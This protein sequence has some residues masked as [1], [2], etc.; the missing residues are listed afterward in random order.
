MLGG[1]TRGGTI[2]TGAR[3]MGPTELDSRRG[4]ADRALVGRTREFGELCAVLEEAIAGRGGLALLAGEPGIGKTRLAEELSSEAG[5]RSALVLWG[6][7]WDDGGAPAYWPWVQIL[8]ALVR[9]RPSACLVREL[10]HAAPFVAH[11]VPE[12]RDKL[13]DVAPAP[14][15]GS[16]EE[17]RF[18]L[19]DAVTAFLVSVASA[20]PMVLVVDD[21][22]AADP[23]SLVLLRFLARELATV[24]I[25]VLGT[26]RDVGATPA[27]AVSALIGELVRDARQI[28]LKGLDRDAVARFVTQATGS[29]PSDGAAASIH[30]ATGGNP[31]FLGQVLELLLD[32]G[33]LP[34]D[35]P[36]ANT[37]PLPP[38][39][40]EAIRARVAMLPDRAADTL[41]LAAVTGTEP[42]PALVSEAA[43]ADLRS[44]IEDFATA[45]DA[46]LLRELPDAPG[47]FRFAHA[48]IRDALYGTLD[49]PARAELHRDVGRAIERVRLDEREEHLTALAHHFCCAAAIGEGEKGVGY[50]VRAAERAIALLA[51]EEAAADYEL[52]LSTLDL[53]HAG[54]IPQRCDILLGLG[55]AERHASRAE[56]SRAA[57]EAAAELATELDDP[58]R[59]AGAALGLGMVEAGASG[60]DDS[61]VVLLERALAALPDTDSAL[62]ARVLARLARE[63]YFGD[64]PERG[65]ELCRRAVE[66]ARRGGDS[67][68]LLEVLCAEHLVTWGPD[69][70]QERLR[71]AGEIVA[72]AEAIEDRDVAMQGRMWRM[73]HLLERGD[74]RAL[75]SELAAFE[76]LA[77]ELRQPGYRRQAAQV[78]AGRALLR[79]RFE[80][81]ERLA[82]EALTIGRPGAGSVAEVK[83]LYQL[84]I[85][86]AEL[87]RLEEVAPQFERFG[88]LYAPW[89]VDPLYHLIRLGRRGEVRALFEQLATDGFEDL[90]QDKFWLWNLAYLAEAAVFLR[91][92]PRAA[93]LYELLSPYRDVCLVI[94]QAAGC[95]GPLAH[96]LGQ[97]AA[98]LERWNDAARHFDRALEI[99]ERMGARPLL[100]HTEHEYARALLDRGLPGDHERATAMLAEALSTARELGMTALAERIGSAPAGPVPATRILTREGEYWTIAWGASTF[101]L[102]HERGLGFIAHLL[103]H[104]NEEIH[105]L[106]LAGT[107]DAPAPDASLATRFN[108][109]TTPATRA[110]GLGDAGALLDP[111]AKAA[112]RQRLADLREEVEAAQRWG[113]PERAA[114]AEAEIDFLTQELARALGLGGKDRKAAAPAERARVSVTK[115]IKRATGKIAAHDERLGRHLA[116]TLRTGTFCVYAPGLADAAD[117]Q[118]DRRM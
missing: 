114:N 34:G 48:L 106:E 92:R 86:C 71:S 117:P 19:L 55:A 109:A 115:A 91:D 89:R 3:E 12:V 32:E 39:A 88:E 53:A 93:R 112:Y 22:H 87:G 69:N 52:A 104:P 118:R 103:A 65:A 20:T 46:G 9:D 42:S 14:V 80:E 64:A 36:G 4:R 90:P 40:R 38:G 7:C 13:P 10:G 110:V 18:A 61:L 66:M 17:A 16:S 23:S 105:A 35:G 102:K 79:G 25:A 11:L 24:R 63:T 108:D 67:G 41:A 73:S 27:P 51:Y 98:T 74:V 60:V 1:V 107:P 33:S 78:R 95:E 50:A 68:V 75:D 101:R 31:L 111:E 5:R 45:A 81:G 84:R 44:V 6:R 21:L 77:R 54:R 94:G 43:G 2:V 37:I 83:F 28:T 26:Y 58:Q 76:R 97:L 59:L 96:H 85:V 70:L 56:R 99:H 82:R 113:D 100:A 47:R 30:A 62:R 8:R 57:F 72:L 116:L 29:V 49:P 15:G